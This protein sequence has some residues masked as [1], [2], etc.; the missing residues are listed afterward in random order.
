MK[1]SLV[2][3]CGLVMGAILFGT[4][5]SFAAT[6]TKNVAVRYAN[7]KI[8]VD[9]T[10]VKTDLEP[11]LLDG[12]TYVPL[13]VAA[14]ALGQE[15]G[16]ENN[17]VIIGKGTQNLVL[18]NVIPPTT[19]GLT[20]ERDKGMHVQGVHYPRG[21]YVVGFDRYSQG[22]LGFNLLGKGVKKIE[23]TVALDDA[24]PD[25]VGTVGVEILADG[26]KA[27]EKTLKKGD[28]P[29]P[30]SINVESTYNLQIK[31]HNSA[32]AQVNFINFAA[33]Y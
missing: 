15:V 2:F 20:L 26:K 27:W 25:S 11:F 13:R 12:R 7:I 24:N 31:F 4:A 33:Q 16:W 23:G 19:T 32:N 17:T 3:L 1:K 14:E 6:G 29:V 9:G 22:S 21:F 30:V 8:V 10:L 18:A 28:N 5:W